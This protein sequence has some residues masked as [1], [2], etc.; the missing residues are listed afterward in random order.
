MQTTAIISLSVTV[1]HLR[2]CKM[3]DQKDKNGLIENSALCVGFRLFTNVYIVCVL[4]PISKNLR[5]VQIQT[6][7]TLGD[8]LYK[9]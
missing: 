8:Q 2:K 4:E 1:I 5:Q 6:N 3:K 9:E 7:Q